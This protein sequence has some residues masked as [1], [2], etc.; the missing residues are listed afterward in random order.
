MMI[1]G[2]LTQEE[3][4]ALS[5]CGKSKYERDLMEKRFIDYQERSNKVIKQKNDELKQLDDAIRENDDAIQK[6]DDIIREK[7]ELI[8]KLNKQ[9]EKSKG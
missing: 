7:D 1:A 6:M 2:I 4:Q 5:Y 9:I 8:G 3:F